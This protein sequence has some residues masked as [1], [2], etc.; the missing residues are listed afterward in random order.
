MAVQVA[1]PLPTE[2]DRLV[3]VPLPFEDY[4]ALPAT[5]RAEYVDGAAIVS[6]AAAAS[7]QRISRRLANLVEAS[8]PTLF[9]VEAVGVWT[10]ERRSRIPDV[11]ATAAPFE[12]SWADA[13]PVLVVEVLSPSTR[14]EDT[15][16]KSG[17]YRDAGISQYW[18]VDREHRAVTVLQ[19]DGTGWGVALDL[20]DAAPTGAVVVGE[21]GRVE[22]DL[23]TLI[24]T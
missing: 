8:C 18:I 20:D 9:V 12:G 3:R 5:H 22:L 10:G 7:H 11:L 16:R 21:H 23:D 13:T 17:E 24:A 6:P 2:V 19:D 1:L 4:L 15:L 14:R